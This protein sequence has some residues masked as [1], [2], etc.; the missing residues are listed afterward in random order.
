MLLLFFC[1]DRIRT[2]VAMAT[3]TPHRLIL[4]KSGN[5]NFLLSHWRYLNLFLEKCLLSSALRFNDLHPD[6][7]F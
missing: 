1:S 4:E 2:L 5:Y 3:Y 6:R 7:L